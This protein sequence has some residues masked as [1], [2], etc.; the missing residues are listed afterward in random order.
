MKTFFSILV[1]IVLGAVA[2][3]LI[4]LSQNH[5]ELEKQRAA[6]AAER[7]KLQAAAAASTSAPASEEL[8]M[9]NTHMALTNQALT[10]REVLT[11]LAKMDPKPAATR[12]RTI[13][14]IIHDLETLVEGGDSSIPNIREFIA[15]G[16]DVDYTIEEG[17]RGPSFWNWRSGQPLVS[18]LVLPPTL[19]LSLVDVLRYIGGENA[20]VSLGVMLN[21]TTN[22]MELAYIAQVLEKMAPG[23]YTQM[24]NT[25]AKNFLASGTAAGQS[26]L[27]GLLAAQGDTS[28]VPAVEANLVSSQG[29]LNVDAAQYLLNLEKEKAMPALYKAYN[30]STDPDVKKNIAS[31][32][33][34]YVGS[35]PEAGQMFTDLV[36]ND[37]V[38]PRARA[39]AVAAMAGG[40]LGPFHVDPPTD[41]QVIQQRITVL[42]GL[43]PRI[44][45]PALQQNVNQAIA[46]LKKSQQ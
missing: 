27:F 23:K 14:A 9:N 37:K 43:Q 15:G 1:G 40:P 26:Y 2:A 35:S 30:Q 17:T 39:M 24:A 33:L 25:S 10:A 11:R 32:S 18:G 4:L 22:G 5:A 8:P 46:N 21:T 3:I 34:K 16:A 6:F 7:T 42:E 45:D 31:L 20:E 28:L 12:V 36:Q 19:R 13:Q 41:P 44:T 38:D 29:K